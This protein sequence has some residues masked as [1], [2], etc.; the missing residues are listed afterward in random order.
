LDLFYRLLH[1][2]RHSLLN[3][4]SVYKRAE[5]ERECEGTVQVLSTVRVLVPLATST[6]TTVKISFTLRVRVRTVTTL[7]CPLRRIIMTYRTKFI[8][9]FSILLSQETFVIIRY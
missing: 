5:K 6:S 2:H 3:T 1:W 9:N 4:H 8:L 7:G